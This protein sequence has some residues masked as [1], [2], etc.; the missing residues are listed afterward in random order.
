MEH[1]A[2]TAETIEQE[3][4]ESSR[5]DSINGADAS[6]TGED[7]EMSN[8]SDPLYWFGLSVPGSLRSA[9]NDF[10][11][12]VTQTIPILLSISQNIREVEIEIGRTRKKMRKLK[13][14][15]QDHSNS[16]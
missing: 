16:K 15:A 2:S 11:G 12:A 5:R 13:S 4:E 6:S 7:E 1:I 3:S 9:K 8:P 10:T 14:P